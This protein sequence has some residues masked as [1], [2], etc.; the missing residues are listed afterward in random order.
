MA[1]ATALLPFSA[2]DSELKD[3]ALPK[4]T[5][6]KAELGGQLSGIVTLFMCVAHCE[7]KLKVWES[8][9]VFGALVG[10]GVLFCPPRG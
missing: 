8:D 2:L 6:L 5:T 7:Q 10:G 9:C 3:R 1:L 4:E